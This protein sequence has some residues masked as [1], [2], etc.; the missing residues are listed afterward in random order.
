MT[1]RPLERGHEVYLADAEKCKTRVSLQPSW[2]LVPGSRLANSMR[3]FAARTET[4]DSATSSLGTVGA[5]IAV[6][7]WMV[8]VAARWMAYQ[9]RRRRDWTLSVSS[10]DEEPVKLAGR[11]HAVYGRAVRTL[12]HSRHRDYESALIAAKQRA[13]ALTQDGYRPLAYPVGWGSR[14]GS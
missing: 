2:G 8:L 13:S 4:A 9:A 6:A 3:W 10:Y 12:E 5:A 14:N 1:D 11:R 7:V